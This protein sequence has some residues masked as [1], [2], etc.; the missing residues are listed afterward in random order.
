[1]T[2]P[3]HNRPGEMALRPR[4]VRARGRPGNIC[5]PCWRVLP[6]PMSLSALT[7]TLRTNISGDRICAHFG[8]CIPPAGGTAPKSVAKELVEGGFHGSFREL[9]LHSDQSIS[10]GV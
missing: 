7:R 2:L 1:M 6:A 4:V 8:R 10:V 9:V 5:K 3:G